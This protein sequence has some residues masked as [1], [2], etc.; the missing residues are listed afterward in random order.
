MVFDTNVLVYA[1]REDA[2]FHFPCRQRLAE[3]NTGSSPPFLTWN[4]C[5][6]FLR[7]ITHPRVYPQ[8]W[9]LDEGCQFLTTLLEDS[10]FRL[11]LATDQHL[12]VLSQI[13]VE[14]PSIRGNPVHDLHTAVLMRE[15]G[16]SQ[17]CTL[18]SDFRRFPFLEVIDPTR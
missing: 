2:E 7:V 8:P 18:D 3:A 4:V 1:A 13:A 14:L 15:H 11:L 16:V 5:Y 10:G 17:I 6:E 12:A 9:D